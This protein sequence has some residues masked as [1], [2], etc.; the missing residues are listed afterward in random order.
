MP[1][2][3]DLFGKFAWRYLRER[4]RR[5]VRMAKIEVDEV[6]VTETLIGL[7]LLRPCEQDDW[8]KVEAALAKGLQDSGDHH[9]A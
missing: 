7:G 2:T 9:R 1:A 8:A 5:G 3:D 6:L 4:R